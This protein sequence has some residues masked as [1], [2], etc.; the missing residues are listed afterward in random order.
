MLGWI[1]L[2]ALFTGVAV[3]VIVFVV[4]HFDK[5]TAKTHMKKNKVK[6]AWVKNIVKSDKV[7]HINLDGVD[8]DGNS[9]EIQVTTDDYDEKQIIKGIVIY[10]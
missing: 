8:E 10:G 9:V 3:G 1:L 4:P 7:V 6:M 5:K 2:G